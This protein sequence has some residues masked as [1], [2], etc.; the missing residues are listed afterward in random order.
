MGLTYRGKH[1]LRDFGMQTKITD[2]P[3]TPPKKTDYEEDIPYRDGSIDFS[4]SGGRVF[5][6]DKTIE[7][8]FYLICNDTAQRNKTIEQFVTWINGGK[9]ELIL[10]D[11]PF[12][13]WIASP[14]TV[15]D[16]TI[17]L[18]RAGKTVVAF[19]CEPF[20]QFLYDTQGIPLGADI[21]LG[22][23]IEIG[24]PINHIYE[25]ANGTNTFKLNNAGNAAVRP[26]IVFSGNFTSVSF[27]CGG[28]TIKYNHKTTQFTIDCE[29]FSCFEGNTNTSEYSNGDYVE[30]G[31]GENEITIQ[32][33]GT[34]TV[35]II[36]NPLFYYTQSIL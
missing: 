27:T 2:L 12:T 22:T 4:E 8:E 16:M 34:G 13:K 24:W 28:N 31:Q 36:Y 23:E 7:V 9:G 6:N 29:L 15:E 30:I 21:P 3:I 1:S 25:I 33:N 18:Q 5:Y 35:E 11:M 17:M 20:N 26:K 32:S 14:I 19:R 10:D